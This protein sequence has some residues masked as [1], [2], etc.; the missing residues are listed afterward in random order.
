MMCAL[1]AIPHLR[2]ALADA[3]PADRY[4][5][6]RVAERLSSASL[7]LLAEAGTHPDMLCVKW[8]GGH[9]AALT[10][11]VLGVS[12][13]NSAPA[14]QTD[15]L[16]RA[17][18]TKHASSAPL[19]W[20][21]SCTGFGTQPAARVSNSS[22]GSG[23]G[24]VATVSISPAGSSD[25][26]IS[27]SSTNSAGAR[28]EGG[29]GPSGQPSPRPSRRSAEVQQESFDCGRGRAAT[30]GRTVTLRRAGMVITVRT[31]R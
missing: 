10:Q 21:A 19:V 29:G 1:R 28:L 25:S 8:P 14:P 12:P 3:G 30:G 5:I 24:S 20:R 9:Q 7:A 26:S 15:P 23:S 13:A 31:K 6:V 16:E 4:M 22:S 17:P 11:A 2:S 27:N 18:A